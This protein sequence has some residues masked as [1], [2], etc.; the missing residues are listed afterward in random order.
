[1][2][3]VV[4]KIQ[5]LAYNEVLTLGVIELNA[6]LTEVFKSEINMP[7]NLL[8]KIQKEGKLNKATT[9]LLEMIFEKL[10]LTKQSFINQYLKLGDID[11]VKEVAVPE[12]IKIENFALPKAELPVITVPFGMGKSKPSK[13][14]IKTKVV[15][16]GTERR[17]GKTQILKDINNQGFK[18]TPHQRAGLKLNDL[19]NVTVNLLNK[20]TKDANSNEADRILSEQECL[21][22]I[23]SVTMFE[24][25]MEA[26]LKKK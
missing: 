24:R 5:D 4:E 12:V 13:E 2:G 20:F 26:I 18:A 8:Y 7:F 11:Y 9:D 16:L 1:M 15:K 23:A 19:K 25:K 6:D 22:I 14:I 3:T 17:Y 10:I 21:E